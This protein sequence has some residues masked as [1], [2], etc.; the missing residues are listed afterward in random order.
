M[1]SEEKNASNTLYL[2]LVYYQS[3]FYIQL[4]NELISLSIPY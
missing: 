2:K 3:T 1:Y 4:M